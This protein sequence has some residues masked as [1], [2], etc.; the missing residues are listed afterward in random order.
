MCSFIEDLDTAT[1]AVR[2]IALGRDRRVLLDITAIVR[3]DLAG[4]LPNHGLVLGSVTGSREGD[5]TL[6][7]GRLPG[8][9]VGRVRVYSRTTGR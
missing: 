4:R 9:A 3:A 7:S 2:A 6:V 5:F 1:R 8:S